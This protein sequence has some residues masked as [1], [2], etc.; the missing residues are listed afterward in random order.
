M[1]MTELQ[2]EP[3]G[4]SPAD[5]EFSTRFK[6]HQEGMRKSAIEGLG[7]PS[8]FYDEAATSYRGIR[9]AFNLSPSDKIRGLRPNSPILDEFCEETP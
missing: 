8:S 5:T 1:V 4:I 7:V 3:L 2:F 9:F 6:N